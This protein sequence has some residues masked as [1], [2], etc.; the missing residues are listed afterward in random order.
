MLWTKHIKSSLIWIKRFLQQQHGPLTRTWTT[1]EYFADRVAVAFYLDASPWGLGGVLVFNGCIVSYFVPPLSQ[2]D[3]AIHGCRIGDSKA[4]QTWGCLA[5]L[6]R[7]RN[8]DITM[9]QQAERGA[10]QER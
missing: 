2:V 8:M 3:E 7:I 1:Q 10:D 5:V 6:V 9:D 4:Q